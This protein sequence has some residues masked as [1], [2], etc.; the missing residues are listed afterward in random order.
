MSEISLETLIYS[1][2]L[3]LTGGAVL[4]LIVFGV[5][6]LRV[7]THL[8]A[9]LVSAEGVTVAPKRSG[10]PFF[11]PLVSAMRRLGQKNAVRDP[12]KLTLL[13]HS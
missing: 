9:R 2:G 1:L 10:S 13:R 7:R 4:G 8:R 5:A 3:L 6:Q 12:E 11:A